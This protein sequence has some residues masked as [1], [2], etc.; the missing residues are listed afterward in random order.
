MDLVPPASG[1]TLRYV[2]E[3]EGVVASV[4]CDVRVRMEF[5]P[6]IFAFFGAESARAVLDQF[7]RALPRNLIFA[8]AAPAR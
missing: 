3:A 4:F 7:R 8:L 2:E 5:V 6:A 1:F